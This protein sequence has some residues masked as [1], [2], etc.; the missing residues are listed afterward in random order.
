MPITSLQLSYNGL[1]A[2]TSS[3]V[4]DIVINCNVKK[5]RID[6]NPSLAENQ[7]F[8]SILTDFST[9]LES[10]YMSD[11]KLSSRAAYNI[12]MVLT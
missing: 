1:T 10:L 12:F 6:G 11:T 9:T 5:L 3:L 4:T 7:K 2:A 8:Y